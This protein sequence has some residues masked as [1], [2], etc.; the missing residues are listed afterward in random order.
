MKGPRL[1][2][3]EQ[4]HCSEWLKTALRHKPFHSDHLSDRF[5]RAAPSID[6]FDGRI[7]LAEL[8]NHWPPEG[9]DCHHHKHL[10]IVRRHLRS[11]HWAYQ[12]LAVLDLVGMINNTGIQKNRY[13]SRSASAPLRRARR[14]S[15][16]Q[17]MDTAVLG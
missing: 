5:L 4:R 8:L 6:E 3:E 12:A 9:H 11:R 17:A 13:R 7:E 2:H 14:I 1:S 10:E 16:A 15:S